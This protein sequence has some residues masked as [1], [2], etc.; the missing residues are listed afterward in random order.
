MGVQA[1]NS[2]VP[3]MTD[4]A[5]LGGLL[6]VRRAADENIPL[7]VRVPMLRTFITRRVSEG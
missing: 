3:K 6:A 1:E 4:E 2:V 5:D 7:D